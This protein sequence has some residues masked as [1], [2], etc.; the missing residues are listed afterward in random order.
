[1]LGKERMTDNDIALQA[2]REWTIGQA[3]YAQ[4]CDDKTL[5]AEGKLKNILIAASEF[6]KF[7]TR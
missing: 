3:V 7:V 5:T 4:P 2:L 6:E 1:M